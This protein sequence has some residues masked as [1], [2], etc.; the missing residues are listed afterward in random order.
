MGFGELVKSGAQAGLGLAPI[1][2]S[3]LRTYLNDKRSSLRKFWYGTLL[4]LADNITG[5][6]PEK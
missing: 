1:K 5:I 6:T 3:A 4:R 2:R